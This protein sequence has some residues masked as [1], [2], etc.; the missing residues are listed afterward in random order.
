M[1][2]LLFSFSDDRNDEPF[3]IFKT[4]FYYYA[5][6]GSLLVFI[7]GV[8]VSWMTNKNDPPVDPDLISPVSHWLL[9]KEKK[10]TNYY[11]VDE[12]LKMVLSPEKIKNIDSQ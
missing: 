11:S 4:S 5:L 6:I 10:K 9:K 3:I 1:S 7:I 8:P 2:K 12:A